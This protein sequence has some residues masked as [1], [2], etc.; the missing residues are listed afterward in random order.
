MNKETL[1]Q[2]IE[3]LK[4]KISDLQSELD[5]LEIGQTNLADDD[6][7]SKWI[8]DLYMPY[9]IGYLTFE[10]SHVLRELDPVA[11]NCGFGD[12]LESLD[13]SDSEEY[14]ELESE[15]EDLESELEDLESELE[16][17]ETED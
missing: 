8:D 13:I 15:L 16:D 17:L 4:E 3:D 14:K 6:E 11:Y 5:S 9:S 1:E 12:Y 7:Y 2:K 10:A